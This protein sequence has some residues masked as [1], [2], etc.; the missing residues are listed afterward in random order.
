MAHRGNDASTGGTHMF[1]DDHKHETWHVFTRWQRAQVACTHVACISWT[2]G[3]TH[4]MHFL[5]LPPFPLLRCGLPS[6][7]RRP[8][9]VGNHSCT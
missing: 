8:N 1:T 2:T 3:D 4:D 5:I 7:T 6:D 9:E